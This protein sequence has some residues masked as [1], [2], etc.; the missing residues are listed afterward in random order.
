MSS[1][2]T[3]QVAE[4]INASQEMVRHLIRSHQLDATKLN[5][6]SRR[7]TYRIS[8]AALQRYEE[9]SK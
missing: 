6:R 7:P 9:A 5:P 3:A 4:R 8:E 1:L 2:S